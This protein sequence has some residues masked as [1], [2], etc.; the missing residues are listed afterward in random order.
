[1]ATKCDLISICYFID[2]ELYFE[3]EKKLSERGKRREE[4]RK[5]RRLALG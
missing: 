2:F 4:R 1:M 5:N 3:V